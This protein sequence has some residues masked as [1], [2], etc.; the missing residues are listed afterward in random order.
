MRVDENGDATF[1]E[2]AKDV[3]DLAAAHG[4]DAIGGLVQD[5]NGGRVNES[6]R[7]SQP[8]Q[9]ALGIFA[10]PHGGPLAQAHQFQL[11]GDQLLSARWVYARE[12][13]VEIEHAGAGKVGGKAVILRQV[14]NGPA[15]L[16]LAG[17]APEDE[18]AAFS[19]PDGGEQGL[20]ERGL[21]CPIGPQQPENRTT[22]NLKR[23]AVDGPDLPAR[24]SRSVDFGEVLGFDGV[25]GIHSP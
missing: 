24:P 25:C 8:L 23:N 11:L 6:L 10:D 19:W 3:A 20:D 14:P 7:Q 12:R 9:H 21:P 22:A 13:R 2:A 16:G 1:F 15:G 4:I 5:E 17:I 18:G